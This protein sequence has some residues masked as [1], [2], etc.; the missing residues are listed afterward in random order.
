MDFGFT[1]DENRYNSAVAY[2]E[3]AKADGWD[4]KPTYEDMESVECA[5]RLTREGYV[6]SI[7]TRKNVGKWKYQ[8]TVHIWN[9]GGAA[10]MPPATYSWEEIN[11]NSTKCHF[12][13]TSG[14]KLF[15]VGFA[16]LAC[17]T[18]LPAARKK[19]EY[20]GWNN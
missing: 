4:C 6:M 16:G 7:I 9:P 15:G 17:G 18:C 20:G 19:L 13:Q 10:V 3:A 5:A 12:C 2:R 1:N 8:A 14:V 11:A